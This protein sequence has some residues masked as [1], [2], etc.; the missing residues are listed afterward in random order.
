MFTDQQV[1]II[2]QLVST[3]AVFLKKDE[4]ISVS[5]RP[6]KT[7]KESFKKFCCPAPHILTEA[8]ITIPFSGRSNLVRRS[9]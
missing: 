4:L 5:Q 7:F 3:Q 1:E 9:L 8:Y 2:S 6:F